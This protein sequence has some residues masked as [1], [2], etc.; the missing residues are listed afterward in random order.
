[1]I[2]RASS[3]TLPQAMA[4]R[5]RANSIGGPL[6]GVGNPLER[7]GSAPLSEEAMPLAFPAGLLGE[8][9]KLKCVNCGASAQD[10]P[11]MRRGPQGPRTLCNACGLM[12]ANKGVMRPPER[13][14][15]RQVHTRRSRGALDGSPPASCSALSACREGHAKLSCLPWLR[16]WLWCVDCRSLVHLLRSCIWRSAVPAPAEPPEQPAGHDGLDDRAVAVAWPWRATPA[17][18][19]WN[20]WPRRALGCCTCSCLDCLHPHALFRCR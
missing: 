14:P 20:L 3:T 15:R 11:M 1:M 7:H 6:T 4:P 2:I 10:T 12:Y 18:G 9:G 8:D 19:V 5:K 16:C 17:G 13:K